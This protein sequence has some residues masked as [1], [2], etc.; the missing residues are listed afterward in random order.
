[1]ILD[2]DANFK[3]RLLDFAKDN[4]FTVHSAALSKFKHEES[5]GNPGR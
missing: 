5:S 2:I 4:D 1:M 3:V